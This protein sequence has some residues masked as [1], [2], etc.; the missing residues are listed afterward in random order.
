MSKNGSAK[1]KQQWNRKFNWYKKNGYEVDGD[2]K[3]V[4]RLVY[5]KA[6]GKPPRGWHIHHIDYQK[7]NNAPENLIA[8]PA[9]YHTWLHL[10]YPHPTLNRAQLEVQAELRLVLQDEI[11]ERYQAA[12]QKLDDIRREFE[13]QIGGV[14]TPTRKKPVQKQRKKPK[15]FRKPRMAAVKVPDIPA[16][17][18]QAILRKKPP[19]V[20]PAD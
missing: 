18:V 7:R 8:L 9:A 17:D 5:T 3:A 14:P 10:V 19:Y 13:T 15:P 2:G 12:Q 1:S 11:Y 20:P 16:N 6:Y 4:H